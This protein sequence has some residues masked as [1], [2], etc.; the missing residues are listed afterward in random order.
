LTIDGE[1]RTLSTN[2]LTAKPW[3]GG[4]GRAQCWPSSRASP[5]LPRRY[6]IRHRRQSPRRCSRLDFEGLPLLADRPVAVPAEHSRQSLPDQLL[7]DHREGLVCSS[8]QQWSQ[9]QP[10]RPQTHLAAVLCLESWR[11]RNLMSHHIRWKKAIDTHGSFF[12]HF[13]HLKSVLIRSRRPR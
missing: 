6:C 11:T 9:F 10:A 7:V 5:E 12:L 1:R 3:G 4:G 2:R 8:S 13:S